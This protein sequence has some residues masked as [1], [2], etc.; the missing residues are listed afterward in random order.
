MHSH[1]YTCFPV[2]RAKGTNSSQLLLLQITVNPLHVHS[3]G[4]HDT[5]YHAFVFLFTTLC[6]LFWAH[7][8]LLPSNT[9][10]LC[11]VPNGTFAREKGKASHG[12]FPF[13]WIFVDKNSLP[14]DKDQLDI[15]AT[16]VCLSEVTQGTHLLTSLRGKAEQPG[17]HLDPQIH[18]SMG[19]PLHQKGTSNWDSA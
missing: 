3:W 19:W 9:K 16:T 7:L 12:W 13:L 15:Q 17:L 14:Q 2:R 11:T 1:T 8:H 5:D 4:H 10:F 18:S 6:H